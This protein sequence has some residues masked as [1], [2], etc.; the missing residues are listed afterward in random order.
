MEL[1][2]FREKLKELHKKSGMDAFIDWPFVYDEDEAGR[3][4]VDDNGTFWF[5]DS[6]A[7]WVESPLR[8][9]DVV[10]L[11]YWR[12]FDELKIDNEEDEPWESYIYCN[13]SS[14]EEIHLFNPHDGSYSIEITVTINKNESNGEMV[15]KLQQLSALRRLHFI[16]K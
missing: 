5:A 3:I 9:K 15:E 10:S 8:L 14:G 4:Y 11:R 7:N 16:I 1:G 13:F 2:H 6:C 12:A